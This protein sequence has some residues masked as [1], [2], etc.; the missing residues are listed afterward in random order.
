[1]LTVWTRVLAAVPGSH[2]LIKNQTASLPVVRERIV[3]TLA[4][5][6]VGADRLDT[7]SWSETTAAHLQAA[8]G[9]DIALDTFPYNGTTT[10]CEAL[11][12]GS[13]VITLAGRAHAGR[14]GLS[15]LSAVGLADLAATDEDGYVNLAVTLAQD[16]PRLA[17][18][19]ESLRARLLASPLCDER[20]YAARFGAALR[21]LWCDACAR[22]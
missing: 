7:P 19:R 16:H 5:R 17:A 15:L 11:L 12:M 10:I 14:V 9:I 4:A 6:G 18:L 3:Q 21:A 1:V 13:P 20:G 22:A 2:L 8:A